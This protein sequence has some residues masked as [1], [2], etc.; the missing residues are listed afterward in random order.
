[1]GPARPF[2]VKLA[3][4]DDQ[5]DGNAPLTRSAWPPIRH[6]PRFPTEWINGRE[7]S[8]LITWADK[9]DRTR[10]KVAAAQTAGSASRARARDGARDEQTGRRR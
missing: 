7:G 4:N 2:T 9:L 6:L 8:R 1:M 3:I 10:E 5:R